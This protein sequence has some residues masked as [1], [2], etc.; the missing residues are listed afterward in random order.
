MTSLSR[1]TPSEAD[2]RQGDIRND[3][4]IA[5]MLLLAA[6]GEQQ[7]PQ[8]FGPPVIAHSSPSLS[9]PGSGSWSRSTSS[10]RSS[11]SATSM[12]TAEVQE[13]GP[14][15]AVG[16]ICISLLFSAYVAWTIRGLLLCLQSGSN[17]WAS[18]V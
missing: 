8:S 2:R 12:G 13:I 14:R 9:P 1:P 16:L 17:A 15:T 11:S 4:K 18:F 5:P 3:D 7:K 6:C 10:S